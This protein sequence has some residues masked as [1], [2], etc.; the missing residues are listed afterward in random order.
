MPRSNEERK[1]ARSKGAEASVNISVKNRKARKNQQ[2]VVDCLCKP[3][4]SLRLWL[5]GSLS[6]ATTNFQ[7]ESWCH[8][9]CAIQHLT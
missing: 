3:W 1:Q 4:T 8:K 2:E 9:N 6:S 5:Q 7:I